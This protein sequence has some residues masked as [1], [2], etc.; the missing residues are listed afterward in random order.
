MKIKKVWTNITG[1]EAD[2]SLEARIFHAICIISML[3]L[4]ISVPL[5]ISYGLFELVEL[6]SLVLIALLLMYYLSRIR[7]R[8]NLSILLFSLV[9]NILFVTNFY[10]NSGIDGP[11]LMF[12]LLCI[13]LTTTVG[14]KK[15]YVY[16]LLLNISE[17]T[18]L[19][20][21]SYHDPALFEYRYPSLISRYADIGS[22]YI[23][24]AL[25]TFA[26]TNYIRYSYNME[27]IIV[28]E[29]VAELKISNDTKNKLLSILA[30]DLKSPLGSIQNYLEILTE[31]NL[32]ETERQ[33]IEA[34][35]L[36]ETKNTQ[37]MLSNLLS[38]SKSQMEGVTVNLLP[39]NLKETILPAIRAQQSI[40]AEKNIKLEENI[41]ESTI[42]L[43]DRDMLQLVIRNLA[44]NAVKF[45]DSGGYISIRSDIEGNKCLIA[46]S[47]SGRGIPY[48]MQE[49]LFSMIVKPTFGTQNE[50]GVG[51]GLALCKEFTELQNG[52]IWFESEPGKGT[53]FFICLSLA[54]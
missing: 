44:N 9:A 52:K 21:I 12:F 40:A 18:I 5:N 46:I 31:I 27:K 33:S 14:P 4:I 53:H 26:A 6:M 50:K 28:E 42:V 39:V 25:L 38:W 24:A 41:C 45:T 47:D 7:K 11:G 35:L 49:D 32:P 36:N 34:S 2:F 54:S 30:H 10:F 43:A 13:F 1:Q 37:Q 8:L 16:W 51:L 20:L 22:S 29:K 3:I 23:L 19:L 17:V 48:K 15:Q